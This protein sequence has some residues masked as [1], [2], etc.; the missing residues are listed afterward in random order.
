MTEFF[1]NFALQFMQDGHSHMDR[2]INYILHV[3]Y[4]S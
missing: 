1:F 3:E 4:K 2:A